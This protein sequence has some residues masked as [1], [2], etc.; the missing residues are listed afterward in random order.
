MKKNRRDEPIGVLMPIYI[1]L[2]QGNSLC[3]YLYLRQAKMS[4]FFLFYSTN[5]EN[6]RVEQV[7]HRGI[8][9]SGRRKVVG[10][11]NRRV[12]MVQIL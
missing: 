1:E 4:F 6:R 5:S 12:N 2:S 8:G 11:G 9:T 3:S 10:R 7:P